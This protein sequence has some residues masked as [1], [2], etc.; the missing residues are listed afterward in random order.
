[1]ATVFPAERN[2]KRQTCKAKVNL[3]RS[4]ANGPRNSSL[5]ALVRVL[6]RQAALEA[7]SAPDASL[8]DTSTD[9]RGERACGQLASPAVAADRHRENADQS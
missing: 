4:A 7:A 6:A 2:L 1:M 5:V 9:P 8:E 3:G